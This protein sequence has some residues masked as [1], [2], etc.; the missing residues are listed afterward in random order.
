[1]PWRLITR[2]VRE[3]PSD[4]S[5]TGATFVNPNTGTSVYMCPTSLCK[6]S[7]LQAKNEGNPPC[8]DRRRRSR[9]REAFLGSM[10]DVF[11]SKHTIFTGSAQQHRPV[12][13]V[14]APESSGHLGLTPATKRVL[15]RSLLQDSTSHRRVSMCVIA[16]PSIEGT[17]GC[18]TRLSSQRP[19]RPL[20]GKPTLPHTTCSVCIS[21]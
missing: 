19:H 10:A 17:P 16:L 12:A 14:E 8:Q 1:M 11:V 2:L 5:T 9:R 3:S 6:G 20:A 21:V 18:P 7:S 4:I 13:F 15:C